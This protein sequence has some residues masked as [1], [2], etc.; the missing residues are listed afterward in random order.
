MI[1]RTR[2]SVRDAVPRGLAAFAV[3]LLLASLWGCDSPG[4]LG[5]PRR[6]GPPGLVTHGGEQRLWLLYKQE[7]TWR[8]THQARYHFEL[9]GYD[10]RNAQHVWTKRV[11]TVPYKSGG[12]NARARILGQDGDRVWL[13]LN[14]GPV[15]LSSADGTVAADRARLEAT[16]PE[17][18]GLIP[19]ALEFFTFDGGLVMITADARRVRVKA[20]DFK[21]TPYTPASE[22]AFRRLTYL[23]TQWNG[24]FQTKEFL[25]RQGMLWNRWIGLHTER[26]A[27]QAGKDEFG[28][29]L[30]SPSGLSDEGVLARRLL[31]TARIGKTRQFSEGRHDRLFDLAR[32]PGTAEY[33]QGGF[34][35]RQ[36][37]R[38]PLQLAE[39]DGTLVPHRT[40]VDAEGRLA[41]SRLDSEFRE[42]W[43]AVLPYTE[44][45]HRWEWSDRLLMVG[46]EETG[47]P[48]ASG[49][50]EHIVVVNLPDGRMQVGQ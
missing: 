3:F 2:S 21:A 39:P 30:K 28:G 31:W 6:D 36:G 5:P 44:L 10:T 46:K 19:S 47:A 17:L 41:L 43:K 11:L 12:I 42:Q 4:K 25:V 34:L 48:G 23:S 7:E 14:S 9:H 50:R 40:R 15:A 37:T 26:E 45:T 13:F 49:Q 32:L 35:V 20:P 16:N 33:L 1:R 24:G 29:H 18:K 22:E 38:S 27:A 8:Y